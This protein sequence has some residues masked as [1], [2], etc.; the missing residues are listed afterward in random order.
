MIFSRPAAPSLHGTP[1]V[2]AADAVLAFEE[3]R[4]GKNLLFVLENGL[5]HLDR[6][7]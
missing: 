3:S 6:G 5:G 1:D 7:R 4:A 2:V